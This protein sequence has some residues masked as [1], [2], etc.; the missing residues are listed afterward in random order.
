[1]ALASRLAIIGG[2]IGGIGSATGKLLH[3]QGAKLALLHA[4]F[5][6]EHVQSALETYGDTSDVKAYE[7]DITSPESVE[8]AFAAIATDDVAFPSILVNAAGYVNLSPLEETTPEDS[9][10]HYMINLY[11]PTLCSQAF[12]RMY[13][14][15]SKQKALQGA[16]PPP[17]GR[18]VNLA[19]QAGHV[20]L[21]LH[22]AYCA[23]KAGLI[24]LT[25]SMASEW[26]P[27]GITS[28]SISPG[29]VWTAL[30][31]K[32]WADQTAREAY[33]AN[34]PTGKFA[35]PEEVAR[36]VSFLCQ[37]DALNING[38]DIRLDGGYTAR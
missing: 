37:D 32:A 12:A 13:I 10:K 19:S 29:P 33:Q 25:R 8:K 21:H 17:G 18:I 11:G 7:C 28:N 9:L 14:A 1:M 22:G 23:S 34:V 6:A 38:T 15:A 36:I 5:E 20:A 2:G 35:E 26:G 24:G 16:P 3:S 31:K 27:H 30:G 4:P